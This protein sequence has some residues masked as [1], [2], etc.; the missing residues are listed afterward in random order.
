MHDTMSEK[1]TYM[2]Q[3]TLDDQ[4]YQKAQLRAEEAGFAS[5]DDYVADVLVHDF[6]TDTPNL[7]HLFTPERMALI[8]KGIAEIEAGHF[9]TFE[10]SQREIE[11]VKEEWRRKKEGL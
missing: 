8:D 7:D 1:G 5:V 10:E 9:F 3:I 11:K 4:L 6:D 2:P